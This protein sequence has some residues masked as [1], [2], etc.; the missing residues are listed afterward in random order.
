[1]EYTNKLKSFVMAQGADLVK[2]ADIASLEGLKTIPTDLFSQFSHT[3]SI[4]VQV[5]IAVFEMISDQPTPLYASVYQT[6]NRLLDEISFKTSRMLQTD[7]F[8]SLPIPASQIL[9]RKNW[10]GAVSHKAVAR[11]AGIGWQGKNLL[12]IT[13][14]YGSRVRLVTV[15]VN[16]P[17][18]SDKPVKNRCGSCMACKDACPVGAI[19]GI[20]TKDH[21]ESRNQA[22]YF[23]KCV[24]KLTVEFQELPEV[25]V[26]ICGICINVCPFGKRVS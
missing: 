19:K 22:M 21:Y 13:P 1:M 24:E 14:Q 16:A 17:L 7:G 8:L 20:N 2:V 23:K 9:D 3:I 4:A 11:M 18:I 12:L 10:C 25:G 26:P 15:L 5:P 6:I